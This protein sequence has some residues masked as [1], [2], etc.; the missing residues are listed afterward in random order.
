MLYEVITC[1]IRE[2]RSS[3]R[4]RIMPA[5]PISSRSWAANRCGFRSM[6][7]TDSSTGLKPSGRR[8]RT[9]V[10]TSYS[11]HYTKLYEEK[12]ALIHKLKV[13]NLQYSDYNEVKA[14]MDVSYVG[15]GGAWKQT[16]YSKLLTL[17]PEGQICIEDKGTVV[18][19]ALTLIIDYTNLEQDHSYEDIVSDGK[20]ESHSYNFV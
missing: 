20:F 2:I 1:S 19:A 8:L 16:E 9:G 10:I 15:M 14:I 13:R 7:K 18:A 11:I 3:S 6:R 12:N 4:T 17:F 5:I